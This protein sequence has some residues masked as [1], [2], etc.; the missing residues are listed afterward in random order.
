[1]RRDEHLHKKTDLIFVFT[2]SKIYLVQNWMEDE[3]GKKQ[4]DFCPYYLASDGK[5]YPYIGTDLKRLEANIKAGRDP[6]Y[7]PKPK[8][9]SFF[10]R[11]FG[12]FRLY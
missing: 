8:P 1:M 2:Y 6:W 12:F 4:V 3:M 5:Q 7:K 9:R 10:S 11:I